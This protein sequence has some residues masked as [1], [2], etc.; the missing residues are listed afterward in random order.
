MISRRNY[1]LLIIVSLVSIPLL[2]G[3]LFGQRVIDLR[4]AWGDVRILG[5]DFADYLGWAVSYGDINGDGYMDIII[6]A[7]EADP[8]DPPLD[9]AGETYVVFGSSN[10]PTAIDLDCVFPDITINGKEQWDRSGSAVASGDIN[11]DGYDDI[12][13]TAPGAGSGGVVCVIFGS[14]SPPTVI[15]LSKESANI[16]VL[17]GIGAVVLSCDVVASG[18]V[19]GDGYDDIIAGAYTASP[20]GR[21]SAGKTYVIFGFSPPSHITIALSSQPPQITIYG[22]DAYELSGFAVASGDVNNDNYDDIIIGAPHANP[23]GDWHQGRTYIVFGSSFPSPPYV[24][25]LNLLPADITIYGDDD[26]ENLGRRVAS[27]D[28]NNNGYNEIIIGS[29]Q[30]AYVILGESLPPTPCIIDLRSESAD[31][32]ISGKSFPAIDIGDVNGDSYG[33]IIIGAH[34]AT[35]IPGRGS[36]GETYVIF[37]SDFKS[38][39]YTI[40]LDTQPADITISGDDK[41]DWSGWA[42]ACGDMNGDGYDDIII[43]AHRAS[44]PGGQYAGETYV[45][46]GGGAIITAHG[47]GGSGWIRSF[48]LLGRTWSKFQAFETETGEVQLAVGD[49]DGDGHDEIAAGHGEGGSSLVKLFEVDGSLIHSFYAFDSGANPGGEVHL[50]VGNFDGDPDLELAVATGYNGGNKVRLFETDGTF[51]SQFAAFGIGGN[52]NGEVHI[53]AADIDSDGIDEIICGHGE[54]GSSWVKLFEVD[55]SLIRSF[56]AFGALNANGE[57]QLAIGNFDADP[58][59]M[60]IAVAHGEGGKSWVKFFNADGT[61]IG[62][63]KAFGSANAQGEVHLAA[64]DVEKGD[65]L[66]ELICGHGEGG[67]SMVKV[68]KADGTVIR[69]FK[70]FGA[71]NAQGEVH[72][73]KSNY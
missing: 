60:E 17:G 42:V 47:V 15:D 5:D 4:K 73:A 31:I 9:N 56:R 66:W 20:E 2:S 52:A 28:I 18:D 49:I 55:G 57:V 25:D 65:G 63:F 10:P 8:G 71:V 44:P 35:P 67:S 72:L 1:Y 50:A 27:G 39:P 21:I 19:N 70:A 37:G 11:A 41:D 33:D 62:S 3:V 43:G 46:L 22:E 26:L 6:G 59:D 16:S 51:I 36:A 53:A 38:P 14:S 13:I 48:S 32:T 24:F 61:F 12:L 34:N 29:F 64:A 45:I 23:H 68:F 54:G 7:P 69:S 58:S 30:E 40:D